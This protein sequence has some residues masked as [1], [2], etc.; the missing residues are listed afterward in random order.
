M[1]PEEN[2]G[3][4][5]DAYKPEWRSKGGANAPSWTIT[6]CVFSALE[7]DLYPLIEVVQIRGR[8]PRKD[9]RQ[10]LRR[11]VQRQMSRAD[12]RDQVPGGGDTALALSAG[13]EY[14]D[15]TQASKCTRAF[16][17]QRGKRG[18]ALV[19]RVPV[20]ALWQPRRLPAARGGG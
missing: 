16:G 7:R 9:Q 18:R 10:I 5:T 19:F 14:L 12:R 3:G 1:D 20:R 6:R 11:S 15:G 8:P 2:V 13:G 17:R 4:F